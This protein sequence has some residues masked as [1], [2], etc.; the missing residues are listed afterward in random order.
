MIIFI[1]VEQLRSADDFIVCIS[2][3]NAVA[4]VALS[5]AAC[6]LRECVG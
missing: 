3:H 5:I 4:A 1:I 2:A 6:T